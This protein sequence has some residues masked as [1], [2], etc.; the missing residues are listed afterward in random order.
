MS[1]FIDK[2]RSFAGFTF[3]RG[4]D[5]IQGRLA[6]YDYTEFAGPFWPIAIALSI[7]RHFLPQEGLS[8][9]FGFD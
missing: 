4:S 9:L 7:F 6:V 2:V 5:A 3:G 1:I 8:D